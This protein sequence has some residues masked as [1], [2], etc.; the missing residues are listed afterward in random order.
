MGR[1][2][3]GRRTAGSSACTLA[4]FEPKS[5][6]LV[7]SHPPPFTCHLT[8]IHPQVL[9]DQLDREAV[10]RGEITPMYFGSAMTNFGVE[11]MLKSFIETAARPGNDAV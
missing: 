10:L 4:S 8:V 5:N 9:G 7:F 2:V 6:A 11:L 1:V 3:G